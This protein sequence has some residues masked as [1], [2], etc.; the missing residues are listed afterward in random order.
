MVFS[1][2]IDNRYLE[3]GMMQMRHFRFYLLQTMGSLANLGFFHGASLSVLRRDCGLSII[4]REEPFP[5]PT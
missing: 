2:V 3:P 1:Q 4:S 5:P